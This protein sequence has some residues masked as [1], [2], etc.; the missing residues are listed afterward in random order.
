MRPGDLVGIG[1]GSS[2]RLYRTPDMRDGTRGDLDKPDIA[3]VV[4]LGEVGV[5]LAMIHPDG[6]TWAEAPA[7]YLFLFGEKLGWRDPLPFEVIKCLT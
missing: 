1:R 7:V 2:A 3:G 5:C 6:K 4:H